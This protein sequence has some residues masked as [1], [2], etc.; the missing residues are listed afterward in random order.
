MI[1]ENEEAGLI[2]QA[3]RGKN[4]NNNDAQ[5][6]GVEMKLVGFDDVDELCDVDSDGENCDASDRLPFDYDAIA[7]QKFFKKQPQVVTARIAQVTSTGGNVLFNFAI[8]V[9]SG[10]MKSDPDLEVKRVAE[11]R[12][13]I[14]LLDDQHWLVETTTTQLEH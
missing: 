13:T 7:L 1:S 12:D 11:L 6:E 10:K 8:D 9:L 2:M 4:I 14:T 5:V 3:L